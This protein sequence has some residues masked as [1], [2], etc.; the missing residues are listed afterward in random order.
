MSSHRLERVRE[1][2]KREIGEALRRELP[3]QEAGVV[4]VNDVKVSGDLRQA[5]VYVSIYGSTEQQKSGLR[6]I[7]ECRPRVQDHI[8]K[9][10]VLKYIPT[11]RFFA[12]D[13]IARG[14]RVL[15]ILEELE[16]PKPDPHRQ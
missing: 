1:L 12:D 5:A 10:V 13:S 3:V 15:S 6:R 16:H 4:S 14:S 11:L 8:A 2:L 7:E 9:A